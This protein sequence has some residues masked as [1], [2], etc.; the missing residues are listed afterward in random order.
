MYFLSLKTEVDW[1]KPEELFHGFVHRMVVVSRPAVFNGATK[2]VDEEVK[3]K[4]D[5]RGLKKEEPGPL[6]KQ[7]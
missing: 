7:V 3:K 5:N 2:M 4:K 6:H 1:V